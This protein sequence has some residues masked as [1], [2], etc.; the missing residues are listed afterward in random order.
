MRAFRLT[1][2]GLSLIAGTRAVLGG[3]IAISL[4]GRLSKEQHKTSGWIPLLTGIISIIPLGIL[5]IS[6]KH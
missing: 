5:I 3:G 1:L 6:K 2:P 4:S